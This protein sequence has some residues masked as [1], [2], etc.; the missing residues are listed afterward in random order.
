MKITCLGTGTPESHKRRASSGYLVEI[1]DDRILL[2]C[3]VVWSRLIE[4][5]AQ[6]GDI[7]HLFFTHLH[8][9][10]MMDYARLI[11]AAWDE[12]ARP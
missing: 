1:G 2:D 3:G 6:P 11:H 9:D 4:A 7:T 8:S 10:H 12:K 5:G